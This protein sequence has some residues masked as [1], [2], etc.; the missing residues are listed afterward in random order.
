[1]KHFDA[2]AVSVIVKDG[3][4]FIMSPSGEILGRLTHVTLEDNHNEIPVVTAKFFCNVVGSEL[5][6]N[7]KYKSA[8]LE[9]LKAEL[10]KQVKDL[11]S[12]TPSNI[13]S[14]EH[15]YRDG[16]LV[17]AIPF[18]SGDDRHRVIGR[19]TGAPK[20]TSVSGLYL[21]TPEN[22][23]ETGWPFSCYEEYIKPV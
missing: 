8:K 16:Q 7:Q 1:M 20:Y 22:G 18:P 4:T 23:T 3:T 13:I 17:S 2:N 14:E 12:N 15:K 21:I 11:S 10:R 19:I 5:E 9:K 6:A